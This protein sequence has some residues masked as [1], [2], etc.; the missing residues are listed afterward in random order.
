MA[1][2]AGRSVQTAF[3]AHRLLVQTKEFEAAVQARFE[4]L[5][6][7]RRARQRQVT[8]AAGEAARM[9]K[10]EDE[11]WAIVGA[12]GTEEVAKAAG[13]AETAERARYKDVRDSAEKPGIIYRVRLDEIERAAD[14]DNVVRMEE[15]AR[16]MEDDARLVEGEALLAEAALCIEAQQVGL[17]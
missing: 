11:R 6:I 4:E 9:K 15:K 14:V 3:R 2:R 12:I 5:T 13:Q 16:V 10:A 7:P 17:C 1:A 8:Q